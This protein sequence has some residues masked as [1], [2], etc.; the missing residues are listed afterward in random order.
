MVQLLL[1]QSFSSPILLFLLLMQIFIYNLLLLNYSEDKTANKEKNQI[2]VNDKVSVFLEL[3]DTH[4]LLSEQVRVSK[5][6]FL[7]YFSLRHRNKNNILWVTVTNFWL[8]FWYNDHYDATYI[9]FHKYGTLLEFILYRLYILSFWWTYVDFSKAGPKQHW[10][11]V[12]L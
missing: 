7:K 8:T 11:F 9:Q 1:H 3:A 5:V 12:G 10:M 2:S 4:K 6:C